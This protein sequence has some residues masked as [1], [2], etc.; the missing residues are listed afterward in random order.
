LRTFHL[1]EGSGSTG[2]DEIK[3]FNDHDGDT[4]QAYAVIAVSGDLAEPYCVEK[5]DCG[6]LEDGYILNQLLIQISELLT[7]T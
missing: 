3:A 2:I 4:G 5:S 7:A 6:W 1:D